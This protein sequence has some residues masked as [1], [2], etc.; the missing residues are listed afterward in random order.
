[1][2]RPIPWMSHSCSRCQA[3]RPRGRSRWPSECVLERGVILQIDVTVRL[4]IEC[5]A[6]IGIGTGVRT[7]HAGLPA[8]EV[9]EAHITVT[10]EVTHAEFIGPH[11]HRLAEDPRVA[12]K[13]LHKMTEAQVRS[14]LGAAGLRWLATEDFLPQQHVIVFVKPDD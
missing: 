8:R 12:I 10:F 13:P 9:T 7:G 4:E 2:I 6:A 14:E 11:V 1:M 3:T 5:F